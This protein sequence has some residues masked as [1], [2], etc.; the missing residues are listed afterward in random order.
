MMNPYEIEIP[1]LDGEMMA[2]AEAR[3]LSLAKPPRSLGMLED[4]SARFA[5]IAGRLFNLSLIHI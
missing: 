3:Q 1:A 2:A 5:G 4:I